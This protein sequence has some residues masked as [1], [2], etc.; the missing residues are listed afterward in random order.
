[1]GFWRLLL[2]LLVIGSHFGG[3]FNLAGAAPV[4]AFFVLSGYLMALVIE[5]SY[6]FSPAGTGRFYLNRALR[7]IPLLGFYLLATLALLLLRGDLGYFVTPIEPLYL[8]I[9]REGGSGIDFNLFTSWG[10]PPYIFSGGAALAP[11][12]WSLVTEWIFYLLAPLL[13]LLHAR[14]RPVFFAVFAMSLG[15]VVYVLAAGDDFAT[16]VAR[17]FLSTLSVFMA[18]ML[19]YYQRHR[20]RRIPGRPVV[21]ALL[22]AVFVWIIVG[23]GA[24]ETAP[25]IELFFVMLGLALAMTAVLS[26]FRWPGWLR[27]A[28]AV[29]GNIAYGV[30]VNQYFAVLVAFSFAE[31]VFE[32]T[33]SFSFPMQHPGWSAAITSVVLAW[34]TYVVLER[35]L[36]SRRDRIRG[37]AVRPS[38]GETGPTETSRPL[39]T[40]Q[41]RGTLL[42]GVI[43]LAA[44]AAFLVLWGD[45]PQLQWKPART[46]SAGAGGTAIDVGA[47]QRGET[48]A[49]WTDRAG[50]VHAAVRLPGQEFKALAPP[51]PS[52]DRALEVHVMVDRAG[53]T[54]AIW[55][56]AGAGRSADHPVQASFRAAGQLAWSLPVALTPD[57]EPGIVGDVNYAGAVS[58]A[59]RQRDAR[60]GALELRLVRPVPAAPAPA[61]VP[62]QPEPTT[63][64]AGLPGTA[65]IGDLA[66]T[67]ADT[68][69]V[70]VQRNRIGAVTVTGE[71][72]PQRRWLA[73]GNTSQPRVAVDGGGAVGVVW[74]RTLADGRTIAELSRHGAEQAFGHAERIGAGSQP[75]VAFDRRGRLAVAWRAPGGAVEHATALMGEPLGERGTALASGGTGHPLVVG[76]AQS[77]F[78]IV[79]D[80]RGGGLVST[81]KR[82]MLAW[83]APQQIAGAGAGAYA[84]APM[85]AGASA[86]VWRSG[87]A[88]IGSLRLWRGGAGNSPL[89][90]PR[91]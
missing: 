90:I 5:R 41:S 58:V 45:P 13:A 32:L 36:E 27:R 33:G 43:G 75:D 85:V 50:R 65:R 86:A 22:M 37:R 79:A 66:V 17:N 87:E 55:R 54:V 77:S 78:T 38:G 80:T 21:A 18:G 44:L 26:S 6:G 11:Q 68:T 42:V 53:G 7:I 73:I 61:A 2:G 59:W 76:D 10:F 82:S 70:W 34:L 25:F 52:A 24:S 40:P 20:F 46:L 47:S 30:F 9:G 14:A 39:R 72:P 71:A 67:E 63:L 62:A 3:L 64:A 81:T 1:M 31:V 49:V 16:Y 15:L 60:S 8:P 84:V 29:A 35:P 74:Q 19:I 57:S 12:T 56:A 69:A 51:A 23:P 88:V 4:F 48:V 91:T 89:L 83:S 28:D